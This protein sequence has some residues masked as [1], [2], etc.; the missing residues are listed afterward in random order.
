MEKKIT[1]P[2]PADPVLMNAIN[3]L[4][5]EVINPLRNWYSSLGKEHW[6]NLEDLF[7]SIDDDLT[8]CQTALSNLIRCKLV[9]DLY[10]KK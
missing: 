10:D 9:N 7:N 4:K 8:N 3:A 6:E 2:V 5:L 1:T